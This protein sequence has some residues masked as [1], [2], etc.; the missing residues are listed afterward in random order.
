MALDS[1]QGAR[2]EHPLYAASCRDETGG[3]IGAWLSAA[4]AIRRPEY[5]IAT[6]C[7]A[8]IPAFAV[9]NAPG[10]LITLDYLCGF[11]L[12]VFAV[13]V[14]DMVNCLADRE[15]DAMFK[16]RLSRAVHTL[17]LRSVRVQIWVTSAVMMALAVLSA[18]RTG[19]W[20]MVLLVAIE[21][22]LGFQYSVPPL[23]GKAR[24]ALQIPIVSSALF[25]FPMLIVVR[26]LPDAQVEWAAVLLLIVAF[27][28]A[29]EGV[30]LVNTAED[31]PEDLEYGI[32]TSVVAL[33]IPKAMAVATG[34]IACG[35]VGLPIALL[36]LG[37]PV[38]AA[39]L[40][41]AVSA[42][43][44]VTIASMAFRV[45][46]LPVQDAMRELL[47]TSRFV[48]LFCCTIALAVTLAAFTAL[49]GR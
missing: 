20:D 45:R 11:L 14:G 15:L 19:H 5:T 28:A 47:R 39:A 27:G 37:T 48:P 1:D 9:A 42:W 36:A 17:G 46:A 49:T 4:L 30:I 10:D 34:M 8:T 13:Q 44:L 35:G 43:H 2:G 32:R 29:E 6:L 12:V 38:W 3:G 24:G 25:L 21:V 33:G 18:S 7:I 16:P 26:S 22:M 41:A 40:V 31:Y 23:H